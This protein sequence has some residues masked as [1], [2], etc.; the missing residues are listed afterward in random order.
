LRLPFGYYLKKDGHIVSF[1]DG[2]V[3]DAG[4]YRNRV[5]PMEVPLLNP[6]SL[7]GA[8]DFPIALDPGNVPTRQLVGPFTCTT[9]NHP[10]KP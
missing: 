10:K 1:L 6:A 7:T 4:T 5:L 3:D 8:E 2:V 9:R